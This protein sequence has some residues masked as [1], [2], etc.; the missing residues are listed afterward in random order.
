L[1]G[2]RLGKGI[3]NDPGHFHGKF[4]KDPEGPA[5]WRCWCCAGMVTTMTPFFPPPPVKEG[6]PGTWKV[7]SLSF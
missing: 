6:T 1:D 2:Q 7:I 3:K 4:I 5:A